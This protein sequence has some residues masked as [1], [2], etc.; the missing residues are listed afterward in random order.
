M[1][2]IS[3][4]KAVNEF[5][6]LSQFLSVWVI[7]KAGEICGKITAHHSKSYLTARIALI[8]YG[9]ASNDGSLISGFECLTGRRDVDKSAMG[10]ANILTAN[11]E[12][13]KS[14]FGVQLSDN[15]WNI[16]N[17]WERDF[18]AAGFDVARVL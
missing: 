10:I 5:D 9:K 1:A 4:D 15:D 13:L 3:D 14:A 17:T 8:L 11:R 2:K 12:K 6:A 18:K 16:F 7:L